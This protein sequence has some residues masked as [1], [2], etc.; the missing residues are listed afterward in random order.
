MEIETERNAL[1][2]PAGDVTLGGC[3]T[4]R[5]REISSIARSARSSTRLV[6]GAGVGAAAAGSLRRGVAGGSG[7]LALV[8]RFRVNNDGVW[9]LIGVED[10]SEVARGEPHYIRAAVPASVRPVQP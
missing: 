1:V 2:Q 5:R 3:D 6:F 9:T 10:P 7:L 4:A 8:A